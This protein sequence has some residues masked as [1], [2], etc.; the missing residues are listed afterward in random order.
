MN[1]SIHELYQSQPIMFLCVAA[2]VCACACIVIWHLSERLPF[3][4]L[5]GWY[6]EAFGIL[7]EPKSDVQAKPPDAADFALPF[8][9]KLGVTL[10]AV[11][12]FVAV[13][14]RATTLQ[15]A[16]AYSVLLW[17]V[18]LVA[19]I[20]V[21]HSII[22]DSIMVPLLWVGLLYHVI[23]GDELRDF[24]L[25][26]AV[27][28]LAPF[29][30][31]HAVKFKTGKEVIGYGDMKSLAMLGTWFG[32]SHLAM[33]FTIVVVMAVAV[34]IGNSIARRGGATPTGACYLMAAVVHALGLISF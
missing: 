29:L 10:L 5:S 21:R 1:S 28:Y 8:M 17:S 12:L 34:T 32:L 9:H 11:A 15:T 27:G 31:L 18:L 30:L 22:P 33:T 25:G 16:F 23:V 19:S 3:L 4:L 6:T 2:I 24:V 14:F 20:N 26:G 13:L 7:G